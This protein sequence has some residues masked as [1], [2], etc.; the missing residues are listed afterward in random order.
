MLT[1]VLRL[2]TCLIVPASFAL[3]AP[4]LDD[5][6]LVD[7]RTS[8]PLTTI[9]DGAV[10]DLAA[11]GAD[12]VAVV[13][14]GSADTR[15]V[16]FDLNGANRF[17]VATVAPFSLTGIGADGSLIP[18]SFTPGAVTLVATPFNANNATGTAGPSITRGF[19]LLR[20]AEPPLER[21]VVIDKGDG[22]GSYAPGQPVTITASPPPTGQIFAGWGGDAGL[23]DDP[24][25]SVATFRMPAHPVAL[26]ALYRPR[27]AFPPEPEVTVSRSDEPL[28]TVVLTLRGPA[29]DLASDQRAF[30]DNRFDVIFT[31]EDMVRRVPGVF[32]ADGVPG[33]TGATAGDQWRVRFLPPEEGVWRWRVAFYQGYDAALR[34]VDLAPAFPWHGATGSFSVTSSQTDD[35]GLRRRGSYLFSGSSATPWISLAS[36]SPARFFGSPQFA[37]FTTRDDLL[38]PSFAA[39]EQDALI[40][41]SLWGDDGGRGFLG[42]T[43]FLPATGLN[44]IAAP[45]LDFDG[46]APVHPWTE[47]TRTSLFALDRLD[48]WRRTV[49]AFNAR[50]LGFRLALQAVDDTALLDD[51]QAGRTFRLYTREMVARFGSLP[52]IQ[53]ELARHHFA[54]H[55]ALK[56][57]LQW[58]KT[59]DAH[60]R[61]RLVRPRSAS[62]S[63]DLTAL[64]GDDCVDGVVL[65]GPQNQSEMTLATW[66]EASADAGR[67]WVLLM[68]ANDAVL[69]PDAVGTAGEIFANER[70]DG[71]WLPLFAKAAGVTWTAG[72]G[73][74]GPDPAADDFRQ[75]QDFWGFLPPAKRFFTQLIDLVDAVPSASFTPQQRDRVLRLADDR[76]ALWFPNLGS[77][78]TVNLA[79]LPPGVYSPRWFN[80]LEN[81][82]PTLGTRFGVTVGGAIDL[83]LPRRTDRFAEAAMLLVRV[84]E[85]PA[86]ILYLYG[87]SPPATDLMNTLDLG[88]LGLRSWRFALGTNTLAVTPR[89][90]TTFALTADNLAAWDAVVFGSNNRTYTAADAEALYSWIE[91][92]GGALFW[93]DPRFGQTEE[94]RDTGVLSNNPLLAPFGLTQFDGNGASAGASFGIYERAHFLNVFNRNTGGTDLTNTVSWVTDGLSLLAVAPPALVIGGRRDLA[95]DLQPLP[96]GVTSP[97]DPLATLAIAEIGAGRVAAIAD[98]DPFRNAG[99]HAHIG[100]ADNRELALRLATWVARR[101]HL[102]PKQAAFTAS[103][104]RTT[105]DQAIIFDAS[106]SLATPSSTYRWELGNGLQRTGEVITYRYPQPGRYAVNLSLSDALGEEDLVTGFVEIVAYEIAADLSLV[107]AQPIARQTVSLVASAETTGDAPLAT[108]VWTLPDGSTRDGLLTTWTPPLPGTYALSLTVTD[109]DDTAVTIDRTITVGGRTAFTADGEPWL[110]PTVVEAEDFDYGDDGNS[111]VDTTDEN[112]G[113]VYRPASSVDIFAS[114]MASNGFTIYADAAGEWTGYTVSSPSATVYEV[115]LTA[116]AEDLPAAFGLAANGLA[117]GAFVLTADPA[118]TLRLALPAGEHELR[119]LTQLPGVRWDALTFAA[120]DEPVLT[121]ATWAASHLAGLPGADRLPDAD[122]DD[123]GLR[124]RLEYA[125]GTDPRDPDDAWLPGL[126]LTT[127]GFLYAFRLP[128]F[129]IDLTPRLQGWSTALTAWVDLPLDDAIVVPA[130]DGDYATWYVVPPADTSFLRLLLVLSGD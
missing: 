2:L 108:Y 98:P 86:R 124:N 95:G 25:A 5:L 123:D 48:Q 73:T 100:L 66:R 105:T 27:E 34:A 33:D 64:L 12:E 55:E 97:T 8:L 103:H 92:G 89:R 40:G 15:S 72:D 71:L 74:G 60:A 58:L 117:A 57:A 62:V 3:A 125:S 101:D 96:A 126:V 114:G 37:G 130:A 36:A 4:S 82:R 14:A 46:N 39:H 1:V 6:W 104:H 22:G 110:L 11:W 32:V 112:L 52:L 19:T 63:A 128:A 67:P 84:A 68:A 56:A 31:R 116:L 18:W 47:P 77:A 122:P 43:R 50:G 76:Y 127:D 80:P 7:A 111:F 115:T 90:D 120:T 9:D 102:E 83:G 91:Q 42:L 53:W 118:A 10:I 93:S 107:P 79:S 119:V 21:I 65:P 45:L 113:G 29:L 13:A 94:G 16:R 20:S 106:S 26:E 24:F 44:T 51:G 75:R 28:N 49:E 88:S 35:L 70:R 41:A 109:M 59:L 85:A 78:T 87:S 38:S 69:P 17:A 30:A 121:Y 81:L 23:L 129:A 54:S 99:P 61:P